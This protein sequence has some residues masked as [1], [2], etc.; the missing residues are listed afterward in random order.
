MKLKLPKSLTVRAGLAAGG[1]V[2][3][4]AATRGLDRLDLISDRTAD[5]IVYAANG[6]LGFAIAA[7]VFGLRRAIGASQESPK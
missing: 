7:F 5:L 6:V 1:A 4:E 3:A 2:L